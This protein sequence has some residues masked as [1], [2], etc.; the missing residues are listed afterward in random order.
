MRAWLKRTLTLGRAQLR[1]PLSERLSK[2]SDL[3]ELGGL[4]CFVIGAFMLNPVAGVFVLG[5]ILI[6][7]GWV[8]HVSS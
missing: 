3:F 5:G 4:A 8:T 2:L 1:V 7:L 6:Y